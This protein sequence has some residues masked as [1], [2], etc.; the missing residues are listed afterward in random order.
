MK[1]SFK[2]KKSSD[3][4]FNYLT[5]MQK[6]VSVHPVITR[7]EPTGNET[8][9]VYETLKLGFIPISFTYPVVIVSWPKDNLVIMHATVMKLTKIEMT[10][11]LKM[12]SNFTII[13]ENIK[14]K[15]PL[16]IKS[17]MK[18]IFNKQHGQLFQNI[19]SL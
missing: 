8:Y 1:L 17:I 12:E 10:F 2:I 4:I 3:L 18:S 14:F 13:E 6:F 11:I 5:D 7:I 19:E 16:P 15:S 9:L